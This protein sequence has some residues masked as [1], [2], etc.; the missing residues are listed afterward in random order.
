M[1]LAN[2]DSD[3]NASE[4]NDST[5]Q[6]A[7]ESEVPIIDQSTSITVLCC[8][9]DRGIA[10]CGRANGIVDTC[11]LEDPT[12]TMRNIYITSWKLHKH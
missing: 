1:V 10:F 12:S 8:C 3:S 2:R 4:A 6:A 7:D 9:K 5:N 11:E